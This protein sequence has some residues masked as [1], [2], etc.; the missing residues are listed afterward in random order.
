MTGRHGPPLFS[1][2][3]NVALEA[4]NLMRRREADPHHGQGRDRPSNRPDRLL[5]PQPTSPTSH[6]Q[7]EA[8]IDRCSAGREAIGDLVRAGAHVIILSGGYGAVLAT[9]Q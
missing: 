5:H 8:S 9:E 7:R 3:Y 1:L 2:N 6:L 4:V